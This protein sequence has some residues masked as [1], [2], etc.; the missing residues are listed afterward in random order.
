MAE[1]VLDNQERFHPAILIPV[2][3]HENAITQTLEE[4]LE[5]GCPV[6]LV[7]DGS[8]KKCRDVLTALAQ[9]YH[10]RVSLL[11]LP[12][13]RGKGGAVKAGFYELLSMGFTHAIQIDA[14]G[15]HD[16]A[17]LPTFLDIGAQ[18]PD[19]LVTGFPEFDVS[20][21]KLRYYS[22]YLTHVW[23]WINTLSFVIRDTMCGFRVYPLGA[24]VELLAQEPCGERM[25]FDTEILVRWVW[26]NGRLINL[27]TRVRYPLDG[28]SHFDVWRDNFLISTMHARL[29]FGMLR[30]LPNILRRRL[31]G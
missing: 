21:P 12:A 29:F 7:D 5:Y 1:F 17:D 23:V 10:G 27:P 16:V 26:R 24:M 22:R 6:L 31:N 25:N 3:D 2:Y 15:Q 11:R 9:Q 20:V 8:G 4:V 14:D 18:N 28:V 30:R 19:A 13:N